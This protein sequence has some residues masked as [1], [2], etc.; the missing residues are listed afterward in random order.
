MKQKKAP[1]KLAL[2][3]SHPLTLAAVMA[4]VIFSTI[5]L[6][7]VQIRTEN[8]VSTYEAMRQQAVALSSENQE[9]SDRIASLGSVE[10][11]MQIAQE[12]LGLVDPDSTLVDPG[13]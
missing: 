6:V 2:G 5:T 4:A 1:I 13:N 8:A 9:L 10:S 3:S 7:Y 12:K 11:A